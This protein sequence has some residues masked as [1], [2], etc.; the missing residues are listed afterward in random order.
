MEHPFYGS[1]GYQTTGYFAPTSRYGTPQDFMYL[2]DH[3]HQHGIGVILD[4][5]PVA[6][7]DRRA[8]PGLLRRHAPVRARRPAPGLSPGLEQLHLQLRP[9][10]GAQLPDLSSALFWLDEYHVDGL[11][12]DAVASMLYLDYSR[13]EGEWIPN[14]LRRPREPGGDRLPAPAQRARS[15]SDYPDVQTIAE[16]STAWPMVSR[17]TYV[18]GLGFGFKWDMGWMHDTLEYMR[19]RPDPPQVPP[20][21]A[22]LPHALRLHTRTSSCRCPTTRWCTARARCWARCPATTGRSSPTC[23]CCTATCT[24]SPARSC[25][26]WA[27]S[28]ASGASGTTTRSLRLA[29]AA[30]TRRTRGMQRWVRR[31]EPRSTAASRRCTS[32]DCDAARLRVDRRQRRRATAC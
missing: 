24:R 19:A 32:C 10:R 5:V 22:D 27:A 29:P 11:R 25:C 26:S 7:P 1:W 6:L 18:G 15:T 13:K 31:P 17:P 16:E 9:Q 3:L 20:Q 28:S 8:R 14:E 4:W 30:S 21:R 2:V 23:G 12:V